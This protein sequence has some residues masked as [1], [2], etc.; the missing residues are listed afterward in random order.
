MFPKLLI[1]RTWKTLSASASERR[2]RELEEKERRRQSVEESWSETAS[3]KRFRYSVIRRWAS[4][5]IQLYHS[6]AEWSSES[7]PA[8]AWSDCQSTKMARNRHGYW[9]GFLLRFHLNSLLWFTCM[10]FINSTV[11]ILLV[12][13]GMYNDDVDI[14]KP[15][16]RL[17]GTQ[18]Q[19][20]SFKQA[21]SF[22]YTKRE[23]S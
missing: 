17:L 20:G 19:S 12:A 14:Q 9:W 10:N 18:E 15:C 22:P 7:S 1:L 23:A 6:E 5:P 4:S 11:V 13:G 21:R 2:G 3:Q 8:E 16:E